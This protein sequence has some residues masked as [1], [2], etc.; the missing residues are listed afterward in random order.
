MVT[1]SQMWTIVEVCYCVF[2]CC[3]DQVVQCRLL[4]MSVPCWLVNM[5]VVVGIPNCFNELL[6]I[7][8]VS[9]CLCVGLTVQ[10]PTLF[11]CG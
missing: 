4:T 7:R 3:E 2:F 8:S 5:L 10:G 1:V 6:L 11:C 9:V